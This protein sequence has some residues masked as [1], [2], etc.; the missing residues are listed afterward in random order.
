MSSSDRDRN[1]SG[2]GQQGPQSS[3]DKPPNSRLFI[4]CSKLQTESDLKDYFGQFG[5]VEDVFLVKDKVTREPKGVAYVK[6]AKF[7]QAARAMEESDGKRVM[8]MSK[9]IKVIIANSRGSH[10]SKDIDEKTELTRL[11]VVVP[12]SYDDD[13]LYKKFDEYGEIDHVTIITDKKTGANKGFGYVKFRRVSGAAN[14]LENCDRSFKAVMAEPRRSEKRSRDDVFERDYS[15]SSDHD[16]LDYG[17]PDYIRYDH[18]RKDYGRGSDGGRA[19]D[20]GRF[21]HSRVESDYPMRGE[22]TSPTALPRA[23]APQVG[24]FEVD[25]MFF[26]QGPG[27][28]TNLSPR[29]VADIVGPVTETQVKGLFSIIPGMEYCDYREEQVSWGYKGTAYVRYSSAAQAAYAKQKLDNFEYPP[30]CPMQVKFV[31]DNSSTT[32]NT[33]S[34]LGGFTPAAASQPPSCTVALPPLQPMA[35]PDSPVE[36]RLFVICTR[37]LPDPIICDVF[38]R[39]GNFISYKNVH[40]R[41]YGYAKYARKESA[42]ICLNTLHG[43]T[44]AGEK[45]KVIVADPEPEERKRPRTT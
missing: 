20:Y 33:G 5:E 37:P 28:P 14:A 26:P 35:D 30:G 15:R 27:L 32:I 9:P 13:E 19:A 21:S 12:S 39:F 1:R 43:Q 42:E 29:L 6:F 41:N 24:N 7:S 17:R 25:G 36:E 23:T 31:E 18:V 22:Y 8:N 2:R 10:S 45:L 4:I 38:R 3:A 40:G 16:R 44:I 34:V 11:F